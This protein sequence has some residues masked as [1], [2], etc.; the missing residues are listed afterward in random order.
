MPDEHKNEETIFKAAVKL[1]SPAE[2]AAYIKTACGDNADLLARIEALLKAHEQ[3]GS[4]LESP[5]LAPNITFG[6]SP[7]TEGPGTVIG[8]YR[9]LEKIGE[10]GMAVVYMAEQQEPIR[11]KVALK[12]IKLGMDT[13]QVIARFEAE[14][15]ALAMMEHASIA[16]VLDAGATDTGRPYFVMELVKGV[17][18]TEYCDKNRLDTKERLD[19]FVSVC[20]AVEHA[21]QKGI[22][23]RDIKPSNVMVTLHDG[24]PVPKVIDFGISKATSQRL[25]EKTLFTRYAQMVGTPEYMS[26]EQAEMSGLDVDT[27]TDVYS[28]GVLLYEL[29][30]G[31]LPFDPDRLRSAGF[32][33]IQRTIAE[34]EPPRPSTRLSDLGEEAEEVA[35]RHGTQ[36]ELL[37]KRLR[38]ELEWIPLKALRKDRTRRYRS[39]AELADDVRNYLD[40][41]PLIAGPESAAYRMRKFVRRKRALVTAVAA[42]AVALLAGIA[43]STLFAMVAHR[44]A[45]AALAIND[46]LCHDL[47]ASADP[48]SG[49]TQGTS[50]ISFLDAASERLKGKFQGEPLIEASI[51]FT[52][53]STYWH[54][55]HYEDAVDHLRRCLEIRRSQLGNEN[56]DTLLCIRELGWVYRHLGKYDE[57]EQLLV[58]ALAG[59]R[60]TLSEEDGTLLYCMGWLSWVYLQQ[61]RYEEAERLQA[62]G[63]EVI[64]RKLGAEHQWVPSFM[65]SIGYIYRC[66]QRFDEA[67]K[68]MTEALDISR[69]T[70][71]DLGIETL[72][73][74]A[75]L[76]SLYSDQGRYQD[77][78]Q[79]LTE[80]LEGRRKVY[81]EEHPDTFFSMDS[82]GWLYRTQGKYE[83]AEQL[84]AEVYQK[85]RKALGQEHTGTINSML[86]LAVVHQ[87]QQQYEQ[88]ERLI[89]QALRVS[90]Q[91]RG[92]DDVMT[93]WS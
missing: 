70:R 49:R 79:F 63:L 4:F 48:W 27:R 11:R 69:R 56:A 73:I 93:A 12:I 74:I 66:Q 64:R 88:A 3:D 54:L 32:A 51:R 44:Q 30:A 2:R 19:L 53:G 72:N 25:T 78:E 37:V 35:K 31:A 24:A 91:K 80:A 15:Q 58:E 47:L 1:K 60:R 10:G 62:E 38:N 89:R 5:L 39:P 92:E 14:R 16:K 76:G 22:I 52:L 41:A 85:S 9:L 26:P 43:V 50:V 83:Q 21:H 17:T 8:R 18:I 46:F 65:Y 59:M 45:R 7:V 13:K 67:E 86:R 20:N 82:L 36:A 57:A 55:G 77:A 28:L 84:L 29:L 90:R 33:Q 40:G 42:V 61:G 87:D 75:V 71:G 68:L 6:E 81:G 23:H 34:E